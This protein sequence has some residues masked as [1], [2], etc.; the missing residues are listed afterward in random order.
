MVDFL[1][2]GFKVVHRTGWKRIALTLLTFTP[3]LILA[4]LNPGI[5]TTALGI[6]GGFGEAFL[7]GLLPIGLLWVGKYS[8]NLKADLKW[9]ENKG[10]LSFL[11]VYSLF[12]IV[13]EAYHLITN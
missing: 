8:C 2:D 11:I 6:A 10:V 13:I 5:F 1:G 4:A 12:V 9:L 7:N 3:P